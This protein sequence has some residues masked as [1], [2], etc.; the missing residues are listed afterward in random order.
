MFFHGFPV[1]LTVRI[2]QRNK[3]KFS[4][5]CCFRFRMNRQHRIFF[6]CFQ[7]LSSQLTSVFTVRDCCDLTVMIGYIKFCPAFFYFFPACSFSVDF[8]FH[9]CCPGKNFHFCTLTIT[10]TPGPALHSFRKCPSCKLKFFFLIYRLHRNKR[11]LCLFKR[12][13]C[14]S[15]LGS[16]FSKKINTSVI[17]CHSGMRLQTFIITV[18]CR[19]ITGFADII[20]SGPYKISDNPVILFC[21]LPEIIGILTEG[22]TSQNQTFRIFS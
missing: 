14:V 10:A 3:N 8:K 13:S 4:R 6:C 12:D 18:L 9:L 5:F 20:P 17:S 22:L 7:C 1:S 2:L 11:P 16:W 19:T 21:N 15:S